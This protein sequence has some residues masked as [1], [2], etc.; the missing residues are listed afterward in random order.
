MAHFEAGID[1]LTLSTILWLCVSEC[2]SHIA[3]RDVPASGP[4]YLVF[5]CNRLNNCQKGKTK[6]KVFCPLLKE[7]GSIF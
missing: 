2:S 7:E 1:I 6:V 5:L 3:S 4:K